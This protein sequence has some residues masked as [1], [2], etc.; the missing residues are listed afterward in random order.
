MPYNKNRRFAVQLETV[1]KIDIAKKENCSTDKEYNEDKCLYEC[2]ADEYI[3]EFE[4]I[5]VRLV[6]SKCKDSRCYC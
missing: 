1:D 4:C 2:L 3:K 6:L 5:H